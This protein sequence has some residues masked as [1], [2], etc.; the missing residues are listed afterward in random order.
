[1]IRKI[2]TGKRNK[3]LRTKC[4]EITEV[5]PATKK[6]VIDMVDTMMSHK[7]IGLAANQIGKSVRVIVWKNNCP[8][9]CMINPEIVDSKGEIANRE[10]CLSLP[11]ANIFKRRKNQI[12]VDYF[13]LDMV[14]HTKTFMGTDAI[15]IQHEIDHLDGKLMTDK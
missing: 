5:T 8:M 3:I 9:R 15:I 13:D 4:K 12:T 1:M 14:K 11:K 6:L 2:L 7:A 10:A